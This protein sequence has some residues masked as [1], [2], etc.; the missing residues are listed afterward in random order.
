MRSEAAGQLAHPL[1]SLVA[2]LGDDVGGP[3]L[4][5]QLDPVLV[6]PEDDDLLGT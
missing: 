5:R 3:E 4:A 2:P 1:D 6:A